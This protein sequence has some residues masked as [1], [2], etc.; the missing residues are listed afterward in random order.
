M[1]RK[2]DIPKPGELFTREV[3]AP[4][5]RTWV[6]VDWY[7]WHL[8]DSAIAD[9]Y[10]KAGDSIVKQLSRSRY[11]Q[12]PE[13]LF[14]PTV[15]LYRHSLELKL[16]H[17]IRSGIDRGFITENEKIRKALGCHDVHRLWNCV[18]RLCDEVITGS[19]V[20]SEFGDAE[21]IVVGFH[22]LDESG[23]NLR[24]AKDFD[25]NDL[26][27]KFPKLLELKRLK[28]NFDY[29]FTLLNGVEEYMWVKC[30]GE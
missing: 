21:G 9:A 17:T 5:S 13:M 18:K 26:S 16:K 19:S 3:F 14:M 6:N 25:G 12:N 1:S 28:L 24:Y 27:E 15:Y 22:S 20:T 4:S 7:R 23:Q 29:I 8:D 10:R 11:R 30:Q 2:R